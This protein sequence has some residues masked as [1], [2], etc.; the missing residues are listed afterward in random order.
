MVVRSMSGLNMTIPAAWR[1]TAVMPIPTPAS[2]A[3]RGSLIAAGPH[4]DHQHGGQNQGHAGGLERGHPFAEEERGQDD[5]EGRITAVDDGHELGPQPVEGVEEEGVRD[6][7]ADDPAQEQPNRLPGRKIGSEPL[8]ERQ[9]R[10]ND[11]GKRQDVLEEIT[12][13]GWTFS[14]ATRKSTTA[15]AEKTAAP[16]ERTSPSRANVRGEPKMLSIHPPAARI[17]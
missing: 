13:R 1:K 5:D 9:D 15:I 6:G 4:R 12:P 7:D 8:S 10:R 17:S 3:S 2:R 14:P 16:T 11:Q